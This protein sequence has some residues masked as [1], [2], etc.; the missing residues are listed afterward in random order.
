MNE[1]RAGDGSPRKEDRVQIGLPRQCF[2]LLESIIDETPW[3]DRQ[4][5]AYRVAICVALAKGIHPTKDDSESY[6]TKFAVGNVDP[7]QSLRD[8]LLA[9][10]PDSGDRPYDYAQRLANKGVHYLHNELVVRG[11]PLPEVL[12]L[13]DGADVASHAD[14]E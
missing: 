12:G 2:A 3:F 6:D 1:K 13:G 10:C 14:L 8:L 7:D 9:M 4:M 11:R 5:D